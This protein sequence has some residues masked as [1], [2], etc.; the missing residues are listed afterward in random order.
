[1]G[2]KWFKPWNRPEYKEWATETED[3]YELHIIRKEP[4]KYL[5]V[6]AK[7]VMGEK[8]LPG[9]EVVEEHRF[10]T[11]QEGLNQIKTWKEKAA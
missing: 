4:E 11:E 5:V 1:M 9:F 2:K 8:G 3:G 10:A 6:K 7:L